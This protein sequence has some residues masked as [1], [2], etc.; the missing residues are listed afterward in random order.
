MW[1]GPGTAACPETTAGSSLHPADSLALTLP[2]PGPD[3]VERSSWGE[4][5][6]AILEM[7]AGGGAHFFRAL[8][9]AVAAALAHPQPSGTDPVGPGSAVGAGDRGVR[10]RHRR[11]VVGLGVCRPG[12]QRHAGPAA[13][14]ADRREDR[15]PVTGARAAGQAARSFRPG[16]A[17]RRSGRPGRFAAGGVRRGT[18]PSVVGRWSLVPDPETDPT[19]RAAAA[20]EVL[21]DRHGIVTRGAVVGRG[22]AGRVRR[23]VPGAGDAG[24]DRS[25]PARLFRRGAGRRAVRLGRSGGPGARVRR[26]TRSGAG[27]RPRPGAGRRRP[28]QPV[29]CGAALARP[30]SAPGP[31]DA[32]ARVPRGPMRTRRAPGSAEPVS[33]QARRPAPAVADRHRPPAGRRA[34]RARRRRGRRC[35]PNAAGGRCCRSPR[36]VTRWQ[37]A[38]AALA[39]RVALGPDRVADRHPDRRCGRAHRRR[40]RCRRR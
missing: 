40:T 22:D 23:R 17:L 1:C 26:P 15:P 11:S 20:A 34:G 19:V 33:G 4:V 28:G 37:A 39:E 35:T 36:T 12:H 24:G 10:H 38:A 8:A 27:G 16:A 14:Q 3:A 25:D 32:A 31:V 7:L 18:P 29:R 30:G 2:V 21:L 9:D 5:H 6:R 13:G